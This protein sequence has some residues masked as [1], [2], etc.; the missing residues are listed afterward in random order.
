MPANRAF[1]SSVSGL[2]R[3]VKRL[4][5]ASITPA[6]PAI[7]RWPKLSSAVRIFTAAHSANPSAVPKTSSA[8]PI[9]SSAVPKTHA[10]LPILHA[11]GTK[12]LAAVR[13][14][15]AAH[16]K[17]PAAIRIFPSAPSKFSAIS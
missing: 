4:H 2:I 12:S 17:I 1:D 8:V 3:D 14:F 15:L 6:G 7:A 13:K 5:R 9:F 11:P 10:A 16:P